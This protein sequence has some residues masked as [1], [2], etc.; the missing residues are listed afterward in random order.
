MLIKRVWFQ[1]IG[2]REWQ[3]EGWYLLGI[4][5][6]YIRDCSPRERLKSE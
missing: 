5:P 2:K 3:R 6:L 1:S 4:I